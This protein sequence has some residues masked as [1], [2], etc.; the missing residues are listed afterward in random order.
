MWQFT[1]VAWLYGAAAIISYLLA[2]FA[3]RMRPAR[4]ATVA[5]LLMASTGTWALGYLLG[6]FNTEL[7]WKLVMLRIEYLGVMGTVFFFALFALV[8]SHYEKW[9][10][11]VT[12]ALLAAIPVICYLLLLTTGL[13][14]FFYRT[15]S[16]TTHEGLIVTEKVYGPAFWVFTGYSYVVV[17]LGALILIL[18]MVRFPVQYRGQIATLVPAVLLP[19]VSNALYVSG[20]NPLVPYDPSSLSF[21][22]AGILVAVSMGSYRLLDSVPIAH[23]LVVRTIKS[24]V[25][26]ID[27]KGQI[28][29][30]NPAAESM[31][32]CS[33]NDALGKTVQEVF[34]EHRELL[35]HFRGVMEIETE[36]AIGD[37]SYELEVTPLRDRRGSASGR[38]IM[39]HDITQRKETESALWASHNQMIALRRMESELSRKLSLDYVVMLGI[40]AALRLSFA[41]A[42]FIAL[43][44]GNELRVA[45]AYGNYPDDFIN[46]TLSPDEGIVGRAIREQKPELVTADT[47]DPD[48][49]PTVPDMRAQIVFPLI[50]QNRLIG[51][52]NLETLRPERFSPY[53]LETLVLLGGR[54]AASLD[55]ARAYE[56]RERLVD[57]LDAYAHTVAHGL[58]NP[59]AATIAMTQVIE[60]VGGDQLNEQMRRYVAS[61]AENGHRMIEIINSLLLLASVRRAGTVQIDS[62]DMAAVV[63]EAQGRLSALID[64]TNADIVVPDKWPKA[65]GYA[66]WVTEIWGNYISNAIK[67]GGEPPRVELGAN[68]RPDG[69]VRFWVRDNGKGLSTEEQDHLFVPFSRLDPDRAEGHGLGLSIVQ[70]IVERLGG[71]TGVESE[72]GKGSVFFFTLPGVEDD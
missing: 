8:Y 72:V 44:E 20:N 21:T 62:L 15:Y 40:D 69:R 14:D 2:F 33:R 49:K 16:L 35:Q 26:V 46:S 32:G 12:I 31:L 36:I 53:V 39:L 4:G 29:E 66:P 59:L 1:P 67:Y 65:R 58:K 22:I 50:S 51:V 48:Y 68:R 7:V 27:T 5:I 6:F 61:I 43:S 57:E 13:H 34:S 45:H 19:V 24:G 23:D 42:A 25:F 17:F 52:L 60:Q 63:A 64:E 56:E 28:L 30:M 3:W 18:A 55:N 70:R 38:V 37:A 71:E 41:N 9:V 10:D 54:L 47:T 11:R